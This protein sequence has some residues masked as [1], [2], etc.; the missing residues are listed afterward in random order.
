PVFAPNKSRTNAGM[1]EKSTCTS[2][3]PL[4]YRTSKTKTGK[5]GPLISAAHTKPCRMIH[6]NLPAAHTILPIRPRSKLFNLRNTLT[7]PLLLL[8]RNTRT[9]CPPQQLH[10]HLKRPL[11]DADL[12][13]AMIEETLVVA[14][15]AV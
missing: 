12:A 10:L 9:P 13:V 8:T 1:T 2:S 14:D 11:P 4:N 7:Q 15:V 5:H 6:F 3:V